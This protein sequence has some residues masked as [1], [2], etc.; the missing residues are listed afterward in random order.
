MPQLTYLTPDDKL[1]PPNQALE[2]PEGLLACGGS[3]SSEYLIKAYAQGVFPWYENGQ[4]ILWWSPNPRSI[5]IP[6]SLH[7]SKSM[8]RILKSQ[9]LQGKRYHITHN[10]AFKEVIHACA[11]LRKQTWITQEMLDAYYQL[12]LKGIA[13]SL[14]VWIDEQLVGGI[15]GVHSGCVFSGESMFSLVSNA[16]KVA[17]IKLCQNLFTNGFSLVDCQVPNTHTDS[18]GA[19]AISRDQYLQIL[20]EPAKLFPQQ[21]S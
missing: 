20:R 15:Y 10:Q 12:Y 18:M 1:P 13:H 4:P 8:Q 3:L 21:F 14:E 7:I 11:N 9:H 5:I 16:S 19:I 2:D 6:E 17:L